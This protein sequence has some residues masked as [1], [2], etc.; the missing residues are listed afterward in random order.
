MLINKEDIPVVA[1]D[2]MNQTHYNEIDIINNLHRLL[3]G[4]GQG[5][6][7]KKAIE[8]F[9]DHVEKH[10]ASEEALMSQ[11]GFPAYPVHKGEHDRVRSELFTI[12]NGWRHNGDTGPL[13]DYL[14]NVHPQWAQNHI[15]TMDNMTAHFL[16]ENGAGA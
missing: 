5:D 13:L 6:E 15:A 1:L 4:E 3:T 16:A 7:L 12:I 8:E 10:F 2:S 11:Y 14:V 9:A